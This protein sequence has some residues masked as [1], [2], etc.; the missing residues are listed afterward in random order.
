M[1]L[2][3]AEWVASAE[4][5]A[6]T[7]ARLGFHGFR[8][9]DGVIPKERRVLRRLGRRRERRGIQTNPTNR[10]V[11]LGFVPFLWNVTD[12]TAHFNLWSKCKTGL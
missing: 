2:L 8:L 12:L 3:P 11:G 6:V 7:I 5:V 9:V 10:L 4:R 1:G